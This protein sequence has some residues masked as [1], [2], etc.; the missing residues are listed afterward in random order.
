MVRTL[1]EDD[2]DVIRALIGRLRQELA[3]REATRQDDDSELSIEIIQRRRYLD[4]LSAEL[5]ELLATP[6]V[7]G[8]FNERAPSSDAAAPQGLAIVIGHSSEGTDKGAQ[9]ISPPFPGSA[10]AGGA[11]Y[12][13]NEDL[14]LQI[15][16]KAR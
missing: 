5:N 2:V 12:F 6:A 16:Q 3:R 4:E 13:W 11:E 1:L 15:E 7:P 14:A 9:G 10:A 8:A